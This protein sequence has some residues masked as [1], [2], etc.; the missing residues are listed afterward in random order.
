MRELRTEI[1]VVGAGPAGIAAAVSAER[2]GARALLVDM[3][4]EPG[5]QIWRGQWNNA[6][7]STARL[8]LGALRASPVETHYGLRLIDLPAAG[9]AVFDGDSGPLRVRCERLV[10]AGGARERL[11]PVPG[12]TLPG[13][14]GAGG[15][16]VLA[17]N[18]WP[19]AGQRVVIAGSG[20]LLLAAAATLRKLGAKVVRVAEQASWGSLAGFGAG[21]VQH[22]R[23]LVQAAGLAR[24]LAGVRYRCNRWVERAE[25]GERLRSV[26]LTDGRQ[27]EQIECDA[28][29]VGFGLLPNTD[30]ARA[31]GCELRDS[32][33]GEIAGCAAAG[34]AELATTALQRRRHSDRFAAH[35]R[36]HFVLRD[37]LRRLAE[38]DTVL[39]RCENVS[40]G[41]AASCS[42]QREARLQLR[43]GMGHC[44][45]RVC[46]AATEFLF[47]WNSATPRPP[48]AP[49]SLACFT[50][51]SS[52]E[53][54][55]QDPT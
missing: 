8:W 47:G 55:P 45:G 25:G 13:V 23:K 17:K 50:A 37:E 40:Y 4:A 34:R 22:P 6:T 41:A 28:L 27:R 19:V 30:I 24:Q 44:Q 14:F 2:A 39:C 29:A 33:Q 53:N 38:P 52:F 11:L 16:Q 42:S 48:L 43:L 54:P 3:Q 51:T 18:G 26:T 15:L 12:W 21:L 7:D 36:R 35:L 5:G 31:L 1:L 10:I 49:A 20:P 9:L 46:G 32:A